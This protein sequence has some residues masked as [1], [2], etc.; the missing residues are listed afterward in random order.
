M[1]LNELKVVFFG[2]S[3]FAVPILDTLISHTNVVGVV[4]QSDKPVGRK[5]EITSTPIAKYCQISDVK[6]QLLNVT[7]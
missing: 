3:D 5:K 4:T 2:T 6:C 7:C 1:K